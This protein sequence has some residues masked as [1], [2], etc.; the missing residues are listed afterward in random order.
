M[1]GQ[2]LTLKA[3]LKKLKIKGN[4]MTVGKIKINQIFS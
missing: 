1:P 4:P 2:S 3:K